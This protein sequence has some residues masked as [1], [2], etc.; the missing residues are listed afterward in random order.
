MDRHNPE[1]AGLG[2][3]RAS[4]GMEPNETKVSI[5]RT[6]SR[7]V[8]PTMPSHVVY[9]LSLEAG[10]VMHWEIDKEKDEWIAIIQK[11]Q[12]WDGELMSSGMRQDR[13]W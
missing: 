8:R 7:S 1:E 3:E 2:R 12:D 13:T 11:K 9:Q 10:A 6:T 5:A 4:K